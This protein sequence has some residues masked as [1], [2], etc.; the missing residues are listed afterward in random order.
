M[1]FFNDCGLLMARGAVTDYDIQALVDD[2]LEEEK[3]SAVR[4]HLEHNP[5]AK[6]RYLDLFA[7]KNILKIWWQKQWQ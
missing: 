5:A 3:A 1:L 4:A 6:K 2:E 7:Q